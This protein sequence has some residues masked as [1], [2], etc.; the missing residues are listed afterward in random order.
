MEKT[1]ISIGDKFYRSTEDG[2]IIIRVN[3][4]VNEDKYQVYLDNRPDKLFNISY[5][6]LKEYTKLKP[7]GTLFFSIMQ[8][9]GQGN[10]DVASNIF[11]SLSL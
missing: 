9:Q 11:V 3:K 2:L 4:I 6:S 7:Y 1:L 5:G 8:L 10:E